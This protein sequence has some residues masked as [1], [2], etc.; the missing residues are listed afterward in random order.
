MAAGLGV[1]AGGG[2]VEE[3][4]LGIAHQGAGHG[5][6]LLLAAG[7]SADAGVALFFELRGADGFVDG[8]AAVEEAAEEAQGLFDGQ[9]FGELRLLKLDADALAELVC[10]GAPV[11]AEEFD[12]RR[13]RG[14]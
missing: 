2:L 11:E 10:V 9:L 5:E 13:C 14:R 7:E 8:D 1:E 6:A 3:E 12:R 4:Q